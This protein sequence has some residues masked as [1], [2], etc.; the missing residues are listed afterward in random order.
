M[1]AKEPAAKWEAGAETIGVWIAASTNMFR[2]PTA[3]QGN[4]MLT[5]NA[6]ESA[7]SSKIFIS[8][9][10]MLARSA[11][12]LA[13]VKLKG[14]G[15]TDESSPDVGSWQSWMRVVDFGRFSRI[16]STAGNPEMWST[17]VLEDDTL[18]PPPTTEYAEDHHRDE[19]SA[20]SA[21]TR[22]LSFQMNRTRRRSV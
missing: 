2:V 7:A 4:D 3:D 1:S 8:S 10:E 9:N 18:F 5:L 14:D 20:C 21:V 6:A 15:S 22:F 13:L 16:C 12:A 17:S 19:P 11:S